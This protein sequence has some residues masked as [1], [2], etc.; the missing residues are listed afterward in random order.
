MK[1]ISL[2][3]G[4]LFFG[5][6]LG[7]AQESTLSGV[8][9]DKRG[10]PVFAANIYLKENPSKG[11]I[12]DYNGN[13]TFSINI[14]EIEYTLVISYIG[15]KA[16]EI[17]INTIKDPLR[18]EILLDD[19]QKML[20]NIIV[21][22]RDPIAEFF[23]VK[24]LEKLDIYLEPASK[25]DPLKA[26]TVL[27]ASTSTDESANPSL[28]GS[29][30]SRS[31]VFL[32][33]VPIYEPVRFSQING[34]G[35][36]SV[37][38]PEIID[39]QYVYA[40]NPP[41]SFGNSSAGLV[42]VNT[43][44][45]LSSNQ[46]LLSTS[47]ASTGIFVSRRLSKH[48]FIQLYGNNQFSDAFLG[49]NK[50]NIP[51]LNH[52]GT[53]DIGLNIN[54][55]LSKNVKLNFFSYGVNEDFNVKTQIFTFT[56]ETIAKTE[57]NFSI[58]NVEYQTGL[59]RWTLNSSY[60]LRKEAFTFGNLES[61][62]D[63]KSIYNALNY[64]Y[65]LHKSTIEIGVNHNHN[66]IHI[67]D[68]IAKFYYANAPESPSQIIKAIPKRTSI[69]AFIYSTWEVN[70]WLIF[71]SGF[72]TNKLYNNTKSYTSSQT[73][74]RIHLSEDHSLLISGGKYHNFSTPNSYNPNFLLQK[75]SQFAIDYS[76]NSE[77]T[78]FDAA[79]YYKLEDEHETYPSNNPIEKI[80]N[81][82]F[83]ISFN[84]RLGDR[85]RLKIGNTFLDQEVEFNDFVYS[86]SKDLNYFVKSSLSYDTPSGLSSSI[87]FVSRPGTRFSSIIG[88]DYDPETNF[89]IPIF[90]DF[91]N[92]NRYS[93]YNNLSFSVSK[94]LPLGS[95]SI[96]FFLSANNILDSQNE[97][98]RR[99]SRD[100][101]SYKVNT[102]EQRLFYFGLVWN[103]NSN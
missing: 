44:R 6:L 47:L 65:E 41:V 15:F 92:D 19:D 1:C 98:Q 101:T 45:S 55:D 12:S 62:N 89:Y 32:N 7:L 58:L 77:Q 28:R 38:N 78:A 34:I 37:L 74:L 59:H 39:K 30:G 64:Q 102:Y 57:R 96:I 71:T 72:R 8:V 20:G 27:P 35:Y 11:V 86:G 75:S 93:N 25:G 3:I 2:T 31:R 50:K 42:Q 97:S 76:Y 9:K 84:Q 52:F 87:T 36:F 79:F 46:I 82:G 90:A 33:G 17:P 16:Q 22:A 68:Q 10:E 5:T 99:Y 91:Y 67:N 81:I 73:G 83:E 13:F 63:R 26:I 18:L 94:Y 48:A 61:D 56:D 100:Y 60:D 66:N 24:K 69:E 29:D 88:G 49:L 70:K 103:L 40:S 53:K 51:D 95:N 14:D 85:I 23:S 54:T 80:K 4:V 21:S 43:I